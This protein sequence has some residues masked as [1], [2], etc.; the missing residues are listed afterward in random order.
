VSKTKTETKNGNGAATT[1]ATFMAP[2]SAS[3][4]AVTPCGWGV[5]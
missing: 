1:L 3:Q 5:N 2:Y 4:R